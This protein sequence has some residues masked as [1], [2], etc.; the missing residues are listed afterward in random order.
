MWRDTVPHAVFAYF[1]ALFAETEIRLEF[2]QRITGFDY[3]CRGHFWKFH[4]FHSTHTSSEYPCQH[5]YSLDRYLIFLR[6]FG[7]L[8]IFLAGRHVRAQGRIDTLSFPSATQGIWLIGQPGAT[9]AKVHSGAR[10]GAPE[11]GQTFS[12]FRRKAEKLTPGLEHRRRSGGCSCGVRM[13]VARDI[14][15]QRLSSPSI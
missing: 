1:S 8:W 2:I 3:C 10:A 12:A 13:T 7:D 15:L 5:A 11:R 9:P 6:H 4:E 14:P